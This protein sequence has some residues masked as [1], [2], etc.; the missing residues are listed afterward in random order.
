MYISQKSTNIYY[1]TI[2]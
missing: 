1:Y 2:S